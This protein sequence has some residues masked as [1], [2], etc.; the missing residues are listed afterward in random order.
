MLAALS[1]M[2]VPSPPRQV[3]VEVQLHD[4]KAGSTG[5]VSVRLFKAWALK[6]RNAPEDAFPVGWLDMLKG[7][8]AQCDAQ[9]VRWHTRWCRRQGGRDHRL[10]GSV[11]GSFRRWCQQLDCSEGGP[12]PLQSILPKRVCACR[13]G[14]LVWSGGF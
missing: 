11:L 5:A 2:H 3:P 14:R 10:V 13:R 8:E 7:W 4:G 6:V 1:S 12:H 9:R